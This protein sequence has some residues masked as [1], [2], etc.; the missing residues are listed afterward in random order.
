[1]LNTN[2]AHRTLIVR[3]LKGL[4]DII[5]FNAVHWEMLE[6]G[7]NIFHQF[8]GSQPIVLTFP[9]DGVLQH[10]T[11]MFPARR[12]RPIQ[13]MEGFLIYGKYISRSI[14]NTKS[15]SQCQCFM[16]LKRIEL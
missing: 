9:K 11:T 3:K 2:P 12:S 14:L 10:P 4:E 15:V 6:K 1:M 13:F 16:I 7:N 5:P 8:T